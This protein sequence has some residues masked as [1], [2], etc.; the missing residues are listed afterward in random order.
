MQRE[1]VASH[2]NYDEAA[3]SRSLLYWYSTA[4][5]RI[6]VFHYWQRCCGREKKVENHALYLHYL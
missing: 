4:T 3:V 5:E 2:Q 1:F 6:P